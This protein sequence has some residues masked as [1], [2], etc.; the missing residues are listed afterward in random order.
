MIV[1]PLRFGLSTRREVSLQTTAAIKDAVKQIYSTP[2]ELKFLKIEWV[3]E[4]FKLSRASTKQLILKAVDGLREVPILIDCG[5]PN[6]SGS[7]DPTFFLGLA[8]AAI[9]LRQ[10]DSQRE[11]VVISVGSKHPND[12]D[13]LTLTSASDNCGV[14]F[15]FSEGGSFGPAWR[16]CLGRASN[17]EVALRDTY[18]AAGP[19]VRERIQ[20]K[21]IRHPGRFQFHSGGRFFPFYY[22]L[23]DCHSEIVEACSDFLLEFQRDSD[24]DDAKIYYDKF[25]CPWFG[26]AVEEAL[27]AAGLSTRATAISSYEDFSGLQDGDLVMLPL[28]RSGNS[29]IRFAEKAAPRKPKFW[30]LVNLHSN[31]D[32]HPDMEPGVRSVP[33]RVSDRQSF[34]ETSYFMSIHDDASG[35]QAVWNAFDGASDDIDKVSSST[36]F[37]ST[38]MWCMILESGLAKETYGPSKVRSLLRTIPNFEAII[39]KNAQ[40]I[41]DKIRLKCRG[42]FNGPTPES[43]IF[44]CVDEPCARKIS[45]AIVRSDFHRSVFMTRDLVNWLAELQGPG[46]LLRDAKNPKITKEKNALLATLESLKSILGNRRASPLRAI[47]FDEFVFSGTTIGALERACNVLKLPLLAHMSIASL[48]GRSFEPPPIVSSFYEF[49]YSESQAEGGAHGRRAV[50]A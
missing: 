49:G 5:G 24:V 21:I 37:T 22:D 19:D 41:A 16:E 20:L 12:P 10:R 13:Y 44:L 35:L 33:F 28:C 2:P 18:R 39:D 38:A 36:S 47:G 29:L 3:A 31:P 26:P 45:E 50:E 30:C 43:V 17:A 48:S 25:V 46:D 8:D 7:I 6:H 23:R 40:F 32:E 9:E 4:Q 42:I 15:L 27:G 11:I 14:T 34:V 1:L